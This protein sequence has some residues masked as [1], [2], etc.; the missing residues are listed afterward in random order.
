MRFGRAPAAQ[1]GQDHDSKI[2]AAELGAVRICLAGAACVGG[3]SV[4]AGSLGPRGQSM[5]TVR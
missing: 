5:M 2:V 1:E 4:V 3:A